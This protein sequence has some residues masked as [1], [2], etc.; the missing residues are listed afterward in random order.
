MFPGAAPRGRV[1]D[2]LKFTIKNVA[3]GHYTVL[4]NGVP[5]NCFVKS[6]KYGGV[7]VP[8][9]GIDIVS[10]GVFELTLSA[11]AGEVSVAA[12]DKDGK[13]TP[14]ATVAL[15]PPDGKPVQANTAN[16]TGAATFRGLKPGEYRI[17]SWE[18]IPQGAWQD[19]EF[20]KLYEGRATTVKVEPSGKQA[21]QVKTIA[22]EETDK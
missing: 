17:I 3:S 16:E 12:V 14:G 4:V 8:D 10:G 20:V 13:P 9:D 22:A 2:D 11:T 21:V 6:V 7:E 15:L 19:P 1:G 5:D 18:D